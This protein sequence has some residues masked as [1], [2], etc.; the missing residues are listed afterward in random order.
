MIPSGAHAGTR[1]NGVRPH[2]V[3]ALEQR[4]L[5]ALDGLRAVAVM[6][7]IV[8]PFGYDRVPGDL[9][10]TLFFV[11]SGFLITWLLIAEHDATQRISLRA[12]Y[13]RRVLRI[14][15]AYY[16]FIC[17]S[18]VLDHLRGQHWPAGLLPSAI[19]YG[20]NYFNA[21]HH[22]PDTSISHA[23]S[24]AVEEQFYLLWPLT[25]ICLARLGTRAR[26]TVLVALVL[27]VAAW[28][29]YLFLVRGVGPAY[30]YNAF[31]T[32]F[33]AL[34]VGCLLAVLLHD[35]T[36]ARLASWLGRWSWQPLVTVTLLVW[37]RMG[38]SPGYHYAL[39]FTVDALLFAILLIQVMCLSSSVSWRWLN[40]RVVRYVGRISYPMY[41]YHAWALEVGRH[42]TQL[43]K[44]AQLGV[45]T[46]ATIAVASGSYFVIERPFLRMK[47]RFER[48]QNPTDLETDQPHQSGRIALGGVSQAVSR[49]L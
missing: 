12:F 46:L 27:L 41:L 11:L 13:L 45:G 49:T 5:P 21:L 29:S 22:H 2:L 20:V 28:R 30:V 35:E 24:L 34:G 14:F 47:A 23:W 40:H 19:A 8:Y 1:G 38:G 43:P 42:A 31:D 32:R 4:H 15:P 9:G 26:R 16:V 33:D 37:S 10:V 18:F 48:N 25:F 3:D 36:I 39:G 44:I 6:T 7:V 17:V